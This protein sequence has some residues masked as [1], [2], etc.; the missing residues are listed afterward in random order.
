MT[1]SCSGRIGSLDLVY[2][3]RRAE[4]KEERAKTAPTALHWRQHLVQSRG[5]CLAIYSL[6]QISRLLKSH[7]SF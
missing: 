7:L 3:R 6:R 2:V 5:S 1:V 4:M